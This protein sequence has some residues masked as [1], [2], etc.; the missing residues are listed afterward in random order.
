MRFAR[1]TVAAY[2]KAPPLANRPVPRP[3]ANPGRAAAE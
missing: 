2:L 1:E 3:P